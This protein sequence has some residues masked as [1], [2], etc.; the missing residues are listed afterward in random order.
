MSTYRAILTYSAMMG[1]DL[2]P[3]CQLLTAIFQ[4]SGRQQIQM[5]RCRDHDPAVLEQQL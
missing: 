4:P 5:P 3:Q 1:L 2:E